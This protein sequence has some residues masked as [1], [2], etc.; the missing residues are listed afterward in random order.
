[1]SDIGRALG[2]PPGSIFTFLAVQGGIARAPRGVNFD[3]SNVSPACPLAPRGTLVPRINK[4]PLLSR[5][6]IQYCGP[7][8]GARYPWRDGA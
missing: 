7:E 8:L 1:M 4:R 2:K 3:P 5:R 6:A